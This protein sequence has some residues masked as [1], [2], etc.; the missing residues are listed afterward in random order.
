MRKT[1]PPPGP[2]CPVTA[3]LSVLGGKWKPILV[4]LIANDCNRFGAMSRAVAGITKQM[5][6]LQLRELEA[7]GVISRT[8]YPEVPPRVE[9]RL[10]ELGRSTFPVIDAMR[11]WGETY[12]SR[13]P[14]PRRSAR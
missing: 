10:T 3:C 5:L 11:A 2:R 7:D 4:Y 1:P 9:Y 14:A 8:V 12:L 13:S 6:T